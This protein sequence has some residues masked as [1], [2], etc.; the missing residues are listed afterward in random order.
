MGQ[1]GG[2]GQPPLSPIDP[3]N[4]EADSFHRKPRLYRPDPPEFT[5]GL[6]KQVV[7]TLKRIGRQVTGLPVRAG[8]T[9]DPGPEFAI[10]SFK[11]ERHREIC[12][13]NTMGKGSM[14]CCYSELHADQEVYAG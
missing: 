9:F 1:M 14:V 7:D 13:G 12:M 6:L 11:Y 10:S 2:R 8:A 3:N 5:Y 4:P